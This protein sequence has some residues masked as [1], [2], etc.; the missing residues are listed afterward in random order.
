MAGFDSSF[1]TRSPVIEMAGF[2]SSLSSEPVI[3]MAG[4]GLIGDSQGKR[5]RLK[6]TRTRQK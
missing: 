3:E 2:G 4:F 1:A 5:P 6:P